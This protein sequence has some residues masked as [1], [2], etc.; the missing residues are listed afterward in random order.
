MLF[1]AVWLLQAEDECRRPVLSG[2]RGMAGRKVL[3][4]KIHSLLCGID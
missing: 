2:G 4:L 3:T 1:F